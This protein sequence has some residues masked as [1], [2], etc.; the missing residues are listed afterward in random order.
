MVAGLCQ[1]T[2][3]RSLVYFCQ[4]FIR[5]SLASCSSVAPARAWNFTVVQVAGRSLLELLQPL[6]FL[7]A[8]HFDRERRRLSCPAQHKCV[9]RCLQSFF[10]HV[11]PLCSTHREGRSVWYTAYNFMSNLADVEAKSPAVLRFCSVPLS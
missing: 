1:G 7:A 9:V 5:R 2:G 11:R 10:V 6:L 3:C 8:R 4:D